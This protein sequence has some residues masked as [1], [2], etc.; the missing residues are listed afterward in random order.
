MPQ[1]IRYIY[2]PV[3]MNILPQILEHKIVAI[4]R[5]ADP[6]DVLRIAEALHEGGIKILEVTFNSPD[7]MDVIKNGE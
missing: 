3:L 2:C 5:G 6:N 4:I 7:A 1:Y